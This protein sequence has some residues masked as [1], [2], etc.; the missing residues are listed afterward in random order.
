M[1]MPDFRHAPFQ[2]AA[3]AFEIEIERRSDPDAFGD[4]KSLLQNQLEEG[5]RLAKSFPELRYGFRREAL[6]HEQRG[7]RGRHHGARH[8]AARHH[9]TEHANLLFIEGHAERR[10]RIEREHP[11]ETLRLHEQ[12]AGR[13]NAAGRMRREVTEG[14]LQRIE[15]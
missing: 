11:A 1:G 3:L 10:H 8:L 2:F 4:A 6:R 9:R 12:H 7:R 15:R 13:D 5:L 14:Y